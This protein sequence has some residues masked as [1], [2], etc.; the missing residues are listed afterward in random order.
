ME[1]R[2]DGV[3]T[4]PQRRGNNYASFSST[5]LDAIYRSIDKTDDGAV[6]AN[7]RRDG[8][9]PDNNPRKKPTDGAST[10]RRI[11]PQM[12]PAEV[13]RPTA[14]EHWTG[15]N[16][17]S[18]IRSGREQRRAATPTSSSSDA[19]SYGG[20]S[21]SEAESVTGVSQPARHRPIGTSAAGSS[22]FP[23]RSGRSRPST[24]PPPP[25]PP[26]ASSGDEKRGKKDRHGSIRNRLMRELWRGRSP[27]SPGFRFANFFNSL[28]HS[29]SKVSGPG[30]AAA[31]GEESACSAASSSSRSCL[32]KTR[33]KTGPPKRTV[34]F[35][36]TSVSVDGNCG[37][38]DE[39]PVVGSNR[40]PLP[41]AA[42]ASTAKPPLRRMRMED[43]EEEEAGESDSSSD[44][45]ELEN[46]AVIGR[47]HDE[48]P[49]YETTTLD[50]YS[51]NSRFFS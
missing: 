16:A 24:V 47:F 41:V 6:E 30:H 50:S 40:P 32:S 31:A 3:A 46:M 2:R 5:L 39:K 20:F 34:K 17:S 36:P 4:S 42:T 1:R 22:S 35:C 33:G 23:S 26:V 9:A 44:L 21:S 37:H 14:G 13:T 27:A 28:F 49:V 25:P 15:R 7:P 45:F 48:L 29:K 38:R 19:S 11:L 18:A 8:E 51:G 12:T 10:A 43:K